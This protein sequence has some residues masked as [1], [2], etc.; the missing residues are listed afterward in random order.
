[1]K[2][3]TACIVDRGLFPSIALCMA[4]QCKQVFYTGPPEQVMR[5]FQDD[6]IGDG[7]E[8]VY[9]VESLWDVEDICDVFVFT[10]IGFRAEQ[11]KL[12]REGKAVWGHMGADIFEVNKG[13]F[14]RELESL[15]MTVPD[16][17]IITGFDALIEHL[18]DKEDKYVKLST[19]RGDWETF[20]WRNLA[21]DLPYLI[22][23]KLNR[24]PFRNKFVFYVFD[25][26][27]A[28]LEDGIDTWCI[29]GAWPEFV[30]HAV[31]RKDKALL[32]GMMRFDDVYG[33]TRLVNELWG[34]TLARF[35]YR[36]AF[37][38]EVRPPVFNDPTC[39][40]GSPP[41][42]L[43]TVLIK[44]L[45]E[46]IYRG[47]LGE[48]VEPEYDDPMGAQVLVTTDREIDDYLTIDIPDD[49]R[50][51]FVS[52]FCFEC[53]GKL[54]VA[55][56]PLENTAGWLVATGKDIE[57]VVDRLKDLKS[58]LPDGFECDVTSLAKVIDDM[59]EVEKEG[60]EYG[61][62]DVPEPAV[63]LDNGE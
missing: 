14:L 50:E 9:R 60:V 26:I 41:H 15:G 38:T 24:S 28:I 7:F 57:E 47:A 29:D 11:A 58:M 35:G 48:L 61:K 33:E 3:V 32:G 12:K 18:S 27:E 30:L 16:H 2:D 19:W 55:P 22:G 13:A 40:F 42:Q 46:V 36:G 45:P 31:E 4:K 44:N 63:V 1:M 20:H 49:L 37:S 34:Q 59:K 43:Q 54:G 23:H 10:D 62:S 5:S 25:P 53:D 56:N 39:R 6:I 51:S 8:N 21:M 52:S 17:E